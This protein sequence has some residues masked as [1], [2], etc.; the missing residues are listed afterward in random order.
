AALTQALAEE[1]APEGIWVNAVAPSII[2]TAA[3]RAAIAKADHDQWPKPAEIAE[4]ISFLVA[5]ENAV[6][7]GAV[8]SVFGKS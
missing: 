2:D 8:V 7:R 5:P 4:T 6:T 1:L 3:N